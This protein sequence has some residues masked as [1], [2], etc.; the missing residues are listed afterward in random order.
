M[1][2]IPSQK[3]HE[4]VWW[5]SSPFF[6]GLTFYSILLVGV[7]RYCAMGWAAK[8]I[9]GTGVMLF[10][11][12]QAILTTTSGRIFLHEEMN[13]I[14]VLG[15]VLILAGIIVYIFGKENVQASIK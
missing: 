9:G 4:G 14:Q 10:M 12:L 1:F 6:I 13:L 2:G 11:L 8:E 5:D 15:G 3:L 7:Y